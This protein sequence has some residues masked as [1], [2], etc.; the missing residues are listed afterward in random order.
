MKIYIEVK[1]G[2]KKEKVEKISSDKYKVSVKEQPE[3][4]KAN[5]AVI[6]VLSNY[7]KVFQS[8]VDIRAGHT[9]KS[10]IIDIKK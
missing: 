8:Q 1:T 7:F 9:S 6:K 3:K 10:K 2:S 4:G 5:K